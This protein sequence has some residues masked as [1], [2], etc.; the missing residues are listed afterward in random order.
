MQSHVG[1]WALLFGLVGTASRADSITPLN[2]SE[3]APKAQ[4]GGAGLISF[5]KPTGHLT[6]YS[7]SFKYYDQA[8]VK[9]THLGGS[10]LFEIDVD[11]IVSPLG[12]ITGFVNATTADNALK[13][14]ASDG[15]V[16]FQSS[17]LL[18]V[19]YVTGM[20][21]QMLWAK[22]GG[23]AASSPLPFFGAII[24]PTST[25]D[26]ASSFSGAP[27]AIDVF[28]TP[29]PTTAIGGLGVLSMLAFRRVGRPSLGQL[30]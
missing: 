12:Q 28:V 15:T 16:L 24:N 9:T 5:D 21:F 26:F 1:A 8:G 7:S 18:A 3:F 29:L 17:H 30:S 23:T 6:A 2:L 25:P 11:L 14:V 20:G 19:S 4:A 22:D 13:V 27:A 10:T